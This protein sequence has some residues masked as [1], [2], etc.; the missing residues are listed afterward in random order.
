MLYSKFRRHGYW[1]CFIQLIFFIYSFFLDDRTLIWSEY[2]DVP[3]LGFGP[4]GYSNSEII[5]PKTGYYFI[6]ITVQFKKRQNGGS[7]VGFSIMKNNKLNDKRKDIDNI[8][9]NPFG[10]GTLPFSLHTSQLVTLHKFSKAENLFIKLNSTDNF[11]ESSDNTKIV[12]FYVNLEQ[13]HHNI[14]KNGASRTTNDWT[15][16]HLAICILSFAQIPRYHI[17]YLLCE[18][19]FAY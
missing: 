3:P 10:E 13:K 14:M 17:L 18:V 12:I 16:K 4:L 6:Y 19:L 11:D 7:S 2:P 9:E 1:Q 8:I 5:I 15:V